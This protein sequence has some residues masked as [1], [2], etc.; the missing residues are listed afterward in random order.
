MDHNSWSTYMNMSDV[1]CRIGKETEYTG[2]T[3][4]L[5]NKVWMD[6]YGD[7][8]KEKDDFLC[9][10]TH[11]IMHMNMFIVLIRQEET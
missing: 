9:K 5:K 8:F 7:V 1:Y 2:V 3:E 11:K 6:K 10:C 4:K